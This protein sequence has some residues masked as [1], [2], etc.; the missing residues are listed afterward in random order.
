MIPK[1]QVH[2]RLWGPWCLVQQL[3][4]CN[5]SMEV[6]L[7]VLSAFFCSLSCSDPGQGN[8]PRRCNFYK[9]MCPFV[10]LALKAS[11]P[12]VYAENFLFLAGKG[13]HKMPYKKRGTV[14]ILSVVQLLVLLQGNLRSF[15]KIPQIP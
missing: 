4:N 6:S 9:A 13:L 5:H 10:K 12:S 15:L 3:G 2:S 7:T 11:P 14:Y 1:V 8:L